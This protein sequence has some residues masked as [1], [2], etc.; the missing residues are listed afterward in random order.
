MLC[1]PQVTFSE[2]NAKGPFPGETKHVT[3]PLKPLSAYVILISILIS[4]GKQPALVLM[5]EESS[6]QA[7][8]SAPRASLELSESWSSPTESGIPAAIWKGH[9]G[10]GTSLAH[11]HHRRVGSNKLKF[12]M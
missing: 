12:S 1:L 7:P 9:W 8:T 2:G 11:A 10:G 6:C 4:L 3:V 5:E